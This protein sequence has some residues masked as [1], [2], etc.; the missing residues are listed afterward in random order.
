MREHH[1]NPVI[2]S[3]VAKRSSYTHVLDNG[4][5][6]LAALNPTPEQGNLKCNVVIVPKLEAPDLSYPMKCF[7]PQM[8]GKICGYEITRRIPTTILGEV[9]EAIL[10]DFR[11][12][13]STTVAA[14]CSS[15]MV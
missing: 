4:F 3:Q 6:I 14:S 2:R 10:V 1:G 13:S 9:G 11:Q 8:E 5:L 7:Y 15:R 12:K